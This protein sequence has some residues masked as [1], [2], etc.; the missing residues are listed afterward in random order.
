MAF[1][2]VPFKRTDILHSIATLPG[3]DPAMNLVRNNIE[4]GGAAL[5]WLREQII[6]PQT[7]CSAVAAASGGRRRTDPRTTD[8]R[9]P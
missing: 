7:D 1:G 9:R 6:A 4:T 2:A 5:S 3:L 8:I